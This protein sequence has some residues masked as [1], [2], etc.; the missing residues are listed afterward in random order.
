MVSPGGLAGRLPREGRVYPL[1]GHL[2]VGSWNVEGL[3][4]TKIEELMDYMI[5]NSLLVL[6][7]QETHVA[8]SDYYVTNRGYTVILSGT[9][10][11][12]RERAGV[13]FIVAP[14]ALSAVIGFRQVS[15]RLCCL[16][17]RTPGGKNGSHQYLRAAQREALGR[18]TSFLS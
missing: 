5:E 12:E 8:N 10:S 18:K 6:C 1:T 3:T 4:A 17:V 11:T 7:L 14:S 13:G 9:G 16:K 2:R 15:A